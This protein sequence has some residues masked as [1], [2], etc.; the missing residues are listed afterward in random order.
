MGG[1]PSLPEFS[2]ALH[3]IWSSPIKRAA[4]DK[5][6]PLTYFQELLL[7]KL[8]LNRAERSNLGNCFRLTGFL[9][10][11]ALEQAMGE[12]ARRHEVVRTRFDVVEGK[13]RQIIA[14]DVTPELTIVDLNGI[15][16]D[17]IV[18][19][20]AQALRRPFAFTSQMLWR[21]VLLRL[22]D[23][24]HILVV[25]VDHLIT[26]AWSLDLLLRELF[27]LFLT[28]STGL[29]SP[30]ADSPIQLAD[31]ANWQRETIRGRTLEGLI[32]FWDRK[33]QGMGVLPELHLPNENPVPRTSSY[34]PYATQQLRLTPSLSDGLDELSR[35]RKVTLPIL[36]MAA[37]VA[38]L[39]H[40]TGRSDIGI[41]FASAK[42]H[43]PETSDVIGWLSDL[44]VIRVDLSGVRDFSSLLNKV[45]NTVLEAFQFQDLP[46][47]MFPGFSSIADDVF[48]PSLTFNMMPNL[49]L[50]ARDQ[51]A[52]GCNTTLQIDP[53][54]LPSGP[55]TR[56][57]G[58]ALLA[59]VVRG[60]LEFALKYEIQRYELAVIVELLD[61]LRIILQEIVSN[62]AV[63]LATLRD[64]IKVTG[65]AT[66]QALQH[67]LK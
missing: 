26:D 22:N 28:Y 53:V 16:D 2:R 10:Y 61:N 11:A 50:W 30:L 13:P 45:R 33:L 36:L 5:D 3:E 58:M 49:G 67:T 31:F 17:L 29:P 55:V 59:A 34:Q 23:N 6:L 38:L 9:N 44:I 14:A 27:T 56:E 64:K 52:G 65:N 40:Y 1:Q 12:V 18:D 39:H 37:I 21:I 35:E 41:R 24:K 7:E 19:H 62:P 20:V 66:P 4:R 63:E 47:T 15:P 46:Y 57:P 8:W 43:R 48:H 51:L 54:T 32:S 60:E 25:A 42:R